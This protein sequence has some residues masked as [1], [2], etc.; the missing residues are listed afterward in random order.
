LRRKELTKMAS[1][2]RP[3]SITYTLDGKHRT[4]DGRR[5]TKDT[6]G[7][8]RKKSRSP[9]WWGK[10]R[11]ANRVLRRVPLCSNKEAARQMLAKLVTDARLGSVG[12]GDMFEVHRAR[13]LI[14]PACESAGNRNDG[15][16]CPCDGPYHLS[17]YRRTLEA[18]GNVSGHVAKARARVAAILVGMKATWLGDIA[19]GPVLEWLAERRRRSMSVST[20]NGYLTA[21]KS[22]TRW[23]WKDKRL[24][25]DPLAHLS[26][27]NAK[28]HLRHQRRAMIEAELRVLL[29]AA[30]TSAIVFRGLTGQDRR[31]LYATAMGTGFRASELASLSPGSFEL[32]AD[33]RIVRVQAGYT[34]NRKE[35]V[36][37]LPADLADALRGYLDGK[38]AGRPLWPGTW[39]VAAA[40]MLRLDLDSGRKAW[41]ENAQNASERERRAT[42]DFLAYRDAAGRVADFHALR[43]SYVTLLSLSGVAPKLAQEL[44][45]HSDIRLTMNVYTHA[46]LYDLAGAVESLPRLLSATAPEALRATGT[47]MSAPR[48]RLVPVGANPCDSMTAIAGATA[49]VTA[50]R[51]MRLTAEKTGFASD[52][53]SMTTDD[54][55]LPGQD[56]NLDKENQNLLCYRY[57]TG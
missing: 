50:D 28:P 25:A 18:R 49:P 48:T 5:I 12:L 31:M 36:Q 53:G 39:N 30:G 24:P 56:S 2:F 51:H 57:T 44:A 46:G 13:P 14:C 9:L 52:F 38:P 22:F 16:P 32:N 27:L 29:D 55:K 7:A 41:L 40:E 54:V 1:L 17:D 45:R 37:P 42:D 23:L 34:K 4:P 19:A 6:P 43:H 33:P 21:V 11:D 8:V 3:I 10:Y 47:D 35:A 26:R 15:T 20:S